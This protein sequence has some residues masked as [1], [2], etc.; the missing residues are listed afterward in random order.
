MAEPQAEK[1]GED[2]LTVAISDDKLADLLAARVKDVH[3]S[4][5]RVET[6]YTWGAYGAL[7]GIVVAV[8]TEFDP[9]ARLAAISVLAVIG[10]LMCGFGAYAVNREALFFREEKARRDAFIENRYEAFDDVRS[11]MSK[12]TAGK[13]FKVVHGFLLML[14]VLAL[15][16]ASVLAAAIVAAFAG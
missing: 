11:I 6:H 12:P 10:M 15:V 7:V 9:L 13:P 2:G 16:F 14:L 3:E 4:I 1:R 5:W 8:T